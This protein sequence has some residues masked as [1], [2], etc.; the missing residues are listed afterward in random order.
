M[1]FI[2]DFHIH[3]HYSRATSKKLIPE[4]IDYW[5]RVKGI[6]VI[7]TGDFTH[8]GWLKELKEKLE[9]AEPGLFRLKNQYKLNTDLQSFTSSAQ[10]VRFILTA[11]ISNIYKKFGKTRKV[12]SLIFAENFADV[13]KIQSELS[14]LG[15]NITS[16]GRPILGLDTRDLLEI[17]LNSSDNIFFVP[18]HIWTPWF[19]ALGSQSGFNSID[20]CFD[21]LADHIYAVETGLSSDPPMNR[22]CSFLDKYTL[23]SNSDAHSPEKLGREANLFNTE[24]SYKA[25]IQA[26]KTGAPEHFLGTIEFFPQEGKYHYD[27]HRKCDISW[28]PVETLKHNGICPE[29]GKKVTIGVMNRIAQLSDRD[30]ITAKKTEMPFY[31]LIPLK[32]IL[33]EIT[34]VGPSSKKVEQAYNSLIKKAVTEFDLLHNLPVDEIKRVGDD[35][36]CEA[37]RR[38]RNGEVF[39]EE[40]FDG[41]Y[42]KIKVFQKGES[43]SFTRQESLFKDMV[44]ESYNNNYKKKKVLL[45]FELEEYKRLEKA[46]Q[47][48]KLVAPPSHPEFVGTKIEKTDKP[49]LN[50][51]TDLL[52]KELNTE[53]LKAVKHFKGPALIIAGPG[54]GKTRTLTCRIANLILNRNINPE[55]ILAVTFTNKAA[56]EMKE[57]LTALFTDKSIIS[58]LHVCTFH[59]FGFSILKEYSEISGRDKHFSVINEDDKKW[60]LR[61]ELCCDNKKINK[62]STEI[63]EAKQKLKPADELE[64]KYMAEIFNRYEIFL[65]KENIFDLDDLLYHS[66][67]IFIAQ[68]EILSYYRKK[69]QWILVDEYQ[70][71]NFAQYQMLK[72][73]VPDTNFNLCVIG[74]P[75]QAIYGFRGADVKY[76]KKFID[77]YKGASVYR[78]KKSYRCSEHILRASNEVISPPPTFAEASVG[79][80]DS[81]PKG[82][83]ERDG[84]V[85]P[86]GEDLGGAESLLEGLNKGVK[87]NIIQNKSDRSEAEFVARTIEK[88]IGG[89]GFFSIDSKITEGNKDAEINSL[90][91]FVVLCRLKEQM[92]ALTKAFNDHSIPFQTIGDIAFFKQEPVNHI[93]DILKL[94]LNQKNNFLKNKVGEWKII[95]QSELAKLNDVIKNNTIKN[96]IIKIIENYFRNEKQ[97]NEDLFKKLLDLADGFG[98]DME[99]FL[100]FVTLGTGVDTYKHNIENVTL[101][102]LHAAK[103]LEFE[104]VFIVGCENGLLPYSL[105]NSQEADNNEERRLLYVG[106][107]R[108][109]KFL[110]L[111]HAEKRF[112]FGKEYHLEKSPYLNN[113]EEELIELQKSEY[114]KKEKKDDGQ[115]S[116]F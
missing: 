23:I 57:R 3:S 16:D 63:T 58:K 108:A 90:S 19:S 97:K 61:K 52:L 29:C 98:D 107:T 41:E 4:Y 88:M 20:E 111:S 53:Q 75:N 60:I 66:V 32:E 51:Q 1:K 43:K 5:G 28:N 56:N 69:Y 36:L 34:G 35:V 93:I 83:S 115:L 72:N 91:D 15:F 26:I 64:D 113:I 42:G 79:K 73:L 25:I 37:I 94:L 102:T 100:K 40:G 85:L 2:G 39:I 87:I 46:Q 77:D 44:Q 110:Y 71:I 92:E 114:I 95:N 12:H 17:V 70:D 9:P 11:E 47:N 48:Q 109:K 21:D 62:I 96:T 30:N 112:M 18:A 59:S 13:E 54:T 49:F 84:K 81:L 50:T 33:A 116:M 55:N 104:C 101:M 105:F 27:G 6:K 103:G 99:K 80:P 8:P 65:K 78:L 7:G 14:R 74:D 106:M 86:F 68:P 76:I 45:N 22:M 24:L 38:M 31:S 10:E 82:G 67:K 89:L